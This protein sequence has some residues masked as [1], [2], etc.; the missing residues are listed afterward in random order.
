[1]GDAGVKISMHKFGQEAAQDECEML[2]CKMPM[3]F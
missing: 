2:S 1:M 3:E